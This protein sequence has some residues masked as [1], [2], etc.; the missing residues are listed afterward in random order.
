[1]RCCLSLA[2]SS[3]R[4][5]QYEFQF[6]FNTSP[7]IKLFCCLFYNV[8]I[9]A[10]NVFPLAGLVTFLVFWLFPFFQGRQFSPLLLPPGD[11]E[12]YK[13]W[14]RNRPQ[15]NGCSI[16]P[17]CFPQIIGNEMLNKPV[18][19]SSFIPLE[20]FFQEFN[21]LLFSFTTISRKESCTFCYSY[22]FRF[23][24]NF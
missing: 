12:I 4:L 7:L 18:K 17:L 21:G 2:I 16:R 15:T 24:V 8:W 3:T 5:M 23:G 1:M 22:L 11:L 6:V 20:S 13:K 19:M 14:G 10:W 9:E